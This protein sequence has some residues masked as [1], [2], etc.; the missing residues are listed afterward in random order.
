MLKR[1]ANTGFWGASMMPLA[2]GFFANAYSAEKPGVFAK[3]R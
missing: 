2:A 3:M 1:L